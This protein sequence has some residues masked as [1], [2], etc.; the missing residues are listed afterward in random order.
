MLPDFYPTSHPIASP[1][2]YVMVPPGLGKRKDR[3]PD[4][5]DTESSN[6]QYYDHQ[7]LKVWDTYIRS[8]GDIIYFS[9]QYGQHEYADSLFNENDSSQSMIVVRC[10]GLL[11]Q[12]NGDERE[13]F[14][15]GDRNSVSICG[16]VDYISNIQKTE[17]WNGITHDIQVALEQVRECRSNLSSHVIIFPYH[18]TL[19]H[20]CLGALHLQ[21][22]EGDIVSAEIKIFNPLP[23][24]GGNKVN[25]Q[26]KGEIEKLLRKI[27]NQDKLKLNS[28]D[29]KHAEQ[30]NDGSSCG[31]ISAE[32]GK[33]FIDGNS[34][35]RLEMKYLKGAFDLRKRHLKE[36]NDQSFSLKQSGETGYKIPTF[37]PDEKW[38]K[39]AEALNIGMKE[40]GMDLSLMDASKDSSMLIQEMVQIMKKNRKVFKEIE[41]KGGAKINVIQELFSESNST[42][43]LKDEK[44]EDILKL[45]VQNLKKSLEYKKKSN[46]GRHSSRLKNYK[47]LTRLEKYEYFYDDSSSD[48]EDTFQLESNS[49]F[50]QVEARANK[51]LQ[52][53]FKGGID[54]CLMEIRD[55]IQVE[56]DEEKER[57]GDEALYA[58]FEYIIM[59]QT[60]RDKRLSQLKLLFDFINTRDNQ[61]VPELC[62]LFQGKLIQ[63]YRDSLD[64]W[65]SFLVHEF[66]LRLLRSPEVAKHYYPLKLKLLGK[67]EVL[68][69]EAIEECIRESIALAL[70][71]TYGN[72][73]K[74]SFLK[75]NKEAIEAVIQGAK[76]DKRKFVRAVV[77]GEVGKVILNPKDFFKSLPAKRVPVKDLEDLEL[78]K[79]IIEIYEAINVPLKIQ[80]SLG[81]TTIIIDAGTIKLLERYTSESPLKNEI[82]SQLTKQGKGTKIKNIVNNIKRGLQKKGYVY[83]DFE[84]F[85]HHLKRAL[86]ANLKDKQ[87]RTIVRN[88]LPN[89]YVINLGES[90]SAAEVL[91]YTRL[92]TTSNMRLMKNFIDFPLHEFDKEAELLIRTVQLLKS[93]TIILD[94]QKIFGKSGSRT[95]MVRNFENYLSILKSINHIQKNFK[96]DIVRCIREVLSGKGNQVFRDDETSKHALQKVIIPLTYLLFVTEAARNPA[97]LLVHCMMLELIQA[98]KLTWEEALEGKKMPMRIKGAVSAARWIHLHYGTT[99]K[100]SYDKKDSRSIENEAFACMELINLE[101]KIFELWLEFKGIEIEHFPDVADN[102]AKIVGL[103]EE[104]IPN[105]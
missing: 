71:R 92:M 1:P 33:D 83:Q 69:D 105:L 5:E 64:L 28:E 36:V 85:I 10:A 91:A 26:V 45:V 50:I 24:A 38:Y 77:T 89:P 56:D 8:K 80:K 104:L 99:L 78:M 68:G 70:E 82:A 101:A 13:I 3:D 100:Y 47:S 4:S 57:R 34:R 93:K 44:S 6:A 98:R 94:E 95:D 73:V 14:I 22:E 55:L 20:W 39:I 32:N 30:Q 96:M 87:A 75:R 61:L 29:T 11:V 27:F 66:G 72:T 41:L 23:S 31:V 59:Q 16:P 21:F 7:I 62:E 49:D 63:E 84:S 54:S 25:L 88:T 43:K 40:C 19:A 76:R 2:A 74:E 79:M 67:M 65:L 58:L 90:H 97:S 48:E 37:I 53:E 81:E 60:G 12:R 42:L 103:L 17:G 102:Y 15:N 86:T 9:T 46:L 52:S 35:K 18:I 51:L